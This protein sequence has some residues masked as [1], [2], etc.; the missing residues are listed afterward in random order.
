MKANHPTTRSRSMPLPAT[1]EAMRRNLRISLA[2]FLLT[3]AVSARAAAVPVNVAE[4][5]RSAAQELAQAALLRNVA[6]DHSEAQ[7]LLAA[8]DLLREAE[9]SLESPLREQARR[10]EFDIGR[11]AG[12]A[13]EPAD[14]PGA[15]RLAPPAALA[16]L[17]RDGLGQLAQRGKSLAARASR[18]G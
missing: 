18:A 9:P 4:E 16:P 11:D 2:V 3:A 10:L 6:T 14:L 17:D 13:A 1:D 8:R 12:S 15:P 7:H 5:L